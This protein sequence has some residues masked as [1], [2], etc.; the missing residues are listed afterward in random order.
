[1]IK[2]VMGCGVLALFTLVGCASLSKEECLNANWKLIGFEDGSKGKAESTIGSHRKS[3]AKV[4]VT[5][6]LEQY[7]TGHSEGVRKFC[8]GTIAY[9]LGVSGGTYYGVCPADMEPGF[10]RAYRAGQA[11]HAITRQINDVESAIN[12]FDKDIHALEDDIKEHEKIIVDEGSSSKIRREQLRIIGD[13]RRQITTLETRITDAQQDMYRLQRDYQYTQNQ[14][15][16][17]GYH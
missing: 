8:V 15:S 12:G 6:D 9:P 16:R 7:R 1:M 5:P 13:L 10:L 2:A 11:L 14:H 3:C 17:M 4:N